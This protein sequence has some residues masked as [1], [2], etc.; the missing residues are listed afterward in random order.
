[1]LKAQKNQLKKKVV[2][3]Q[4]INVDFWLREAI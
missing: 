1:M 4:I 3:Y 2:P